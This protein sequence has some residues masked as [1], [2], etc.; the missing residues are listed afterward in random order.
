MRSDAEMDRSP[1]LLI[2]IDGVIS[3][4]GFDPERRPPGVFCHVDGIP[5]YLSSGA[6]ARIARLT[7][8]FECVWCSGWEDRADEYLPHHLGLPAGLPHLVF[9][10]VA[11]A[12]G[13]HWKLAAID[14]HAGATRPLAWIDDDHD[15]SCL[16]WA[17]DRPGP[18]LLVATEP[19]G[20]L[21]DAHV[22]ELQ[23]FAEQVRNL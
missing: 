13:R 17:A 5:H 14:A 2:D 20:G 19:A 4:W 22:T 8:S 12:P 21:L 16:A 23:R 1:L 11:G 3:L 18:T 15:E 7:G 9:D 6:A 10:T